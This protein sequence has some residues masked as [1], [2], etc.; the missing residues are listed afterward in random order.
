M[1]GDAS[2]FPFVFLLSN[3]NAQQVSKFTIII[4]I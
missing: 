2:L 4:L 1:H 3:E